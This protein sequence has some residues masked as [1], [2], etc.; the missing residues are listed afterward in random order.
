MLNITNY[1]R[2]TNQNY[3]ISHWSEWPSL[4]SLQITNAGEGVKKKE[5]SY[6]VG[7]NVN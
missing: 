1:Q 2:N 3:I 6:M 7:R 5:P 4:K